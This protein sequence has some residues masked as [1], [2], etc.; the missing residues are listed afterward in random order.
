[1]FFLKIIPCAK[2]KYTK[3]DDDIYY[4]PAK[5]VTFTRVHF[6]LYLMWLSELD[7][8]ASNF[9]GNFYLI[10]EWKDSRLAFP[11]EIFEKSKPFITEFL[12]HKNP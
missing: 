1:M 11:H 3:P 10:F 4:G 8:S 6:F 7:C 5:N 12:Y 9:Q 2:D